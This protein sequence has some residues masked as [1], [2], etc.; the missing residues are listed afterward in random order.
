M[1]GA[2]RVNVYTV[3]VNQL[4]SSRN[5]GKCPCVICEWNMSKTKNAKKRFDVIVGCE[6]I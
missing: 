6:H 3:A 1:L 5:T 4:W 2:L